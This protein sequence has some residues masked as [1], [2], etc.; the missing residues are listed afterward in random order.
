MARAEMT[1]HLNIKNLDRVKLL[2]WELETLCNDMRVGASPF[3][4]RLETLLERFDGGDQ[5]GD[6]LEEP[7]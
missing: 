6:R 3:A 7:A 1:V 4:E 2:R 5:D